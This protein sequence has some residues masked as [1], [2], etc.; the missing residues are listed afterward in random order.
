MSD[1][2]FMKQLRL[3]GKVVLVTGAT[4]ILGRCFC[5]GFAEMGA[6]VVVVDL[7]REMVRECS[8]ELSQ[9]HGI[10]C[11]GISCD[12]S[13]VSSVQEM[14]SAAVSKFG[15]ID[16]L[17][18][19]A[20]TKGTSLK[21]FFADFESYSLETWRQIMSV[22][23]DGMF[24]VAQ[25]VGKQMTAQGHG[26]SII[27][28]SSIYGLVAPDQRIYEKSFYLGESINTPAVYSTS[29]AAVLGLTRYLATYW[30][31]HNIRVNC[32]APGGVESGQNLEFLSRYSFRVPLGRMAKA[33]EIVGMALFLASDASSYVTG[34]TIAVDGGWTCW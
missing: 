23:L 28:M 13:S 24:I 4:G 15:R 11:M 3:D 31:S 19:N 16:V 20:A 9:K 29:K 26:G 30:S 8:T 18:N 10:D 6:N 33:E 25:Q 14:V 12:V 21:D 7:D 27:Q 1:T 34:Q 17:H 32:I 2:F 22:N 5:D